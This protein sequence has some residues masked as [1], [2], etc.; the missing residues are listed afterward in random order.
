MRA[1][2]QK[3]SISILSFFLVFF[4][5]AQTD[6]YTTSTTWTVPA[7]IFNLTIKVYGGAGGTGGQDCGA[8]CSN[9]AAGPVG[10]IL[11]DFPVTPGDIIGIYPGGKGND[12]ANSV[13]GTGGGTGGID[14][15]PSGNY[16]GGNG[17]NT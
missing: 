5:Q 7:G 17:G 10:F 12:G 6:I 15:Y 3:I 2:L 4:S 9:P 8:G 13:S 14:T 11:A 1:Y 16:N